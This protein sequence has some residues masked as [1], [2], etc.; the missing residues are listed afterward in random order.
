MLHHHVVDHL[1]DQDRLADPGTTEQPR[2]AAPLQR[3]QHV[4]HLD[5]RL[6][7]LRLAGLLHQRNGGLMDRPP[8]H[9]PQGLAVVDRLAEDVE[10]AAEQR[11]TDGNP[12][13]GAAVAHRRPAEQP[14]GGAERHR[15]RHIGTEVGHHLQHHIPVGAGL[16]PVQ[17]IRE[18]LREMHIDDALAD[19]DDRSPVDD[20][21]FARR[22]GHAAK[23]P[24]PCI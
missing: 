1:G 2:L 6:D 9:R 8:G 23:R 3:R 12:Q 11:L 7:D 4:D 14:C 15:P 19:G 18:A 13:A 21:V 17:Q 22:V 20:R 10:H 5:A 24:C 16:E